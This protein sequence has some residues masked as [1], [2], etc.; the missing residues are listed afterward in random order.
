MPTGAWSGSRSE[1]LASFS[2][3][4]RQDGERFY[5]YTTYGQHRGIAGNTVG[6]GINLHAPGEL[7]A[8][9]FRNRSILLEWGGGWRPV[10]DLQLRWALFDQQR[11]RPEFFGS[12]DLQ[13]RG[14]ELETEAALGEATLVTATFTL[15]DARYDQSSPAEFGGGSLWNVYAPG[16]GPTS[17]GNGLGYIGGFFLNSLPP[18]DYQLPGLSRWQV[19]LGLR[20]RV[21][22]HW[23]L[24]VWGTLQ[25]RQRGNLAGEY[26]IPTQMEWNAALTYTAGRWDIQVVARNLLDADNWLHNGD[27][28]FDQ[29]L[30]SRNE[31]LRMEGRL[32]LRF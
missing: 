5:H 29:M 17:D 14:V 4:L 30:V 22:E 2:L 23:L 21:D 8:D 27:T 18:G 3:T 19:T 7:H 1:N 16:A 26:T 9:D 12:A 10:D 20:H 24:Q 28:F 31:P 13:V 11:T 15:L 6:D 32:R 25:G